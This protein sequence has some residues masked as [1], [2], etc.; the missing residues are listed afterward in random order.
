MEEGQPLSQVLQAKNRPIFPSQIFSLRR[1]TYLHQLRDEKNN[2]R[3]FPCHPQVGVGR[4]DSWVPGLC[5]TEEQAS[6]LSVPFPQIYTMLLLLSM[7]GQRPLEV[8]DICNGSGLD[9]LET[10][11][12]S[13]TFPLS[14]Y[15]HVGHRLGTKGM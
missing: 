2:G 6:E 8:R 4:L 12:G 1:T 13:A 11:L 15:L 5:L 3:K 10:G 7:E 14:L 9:P